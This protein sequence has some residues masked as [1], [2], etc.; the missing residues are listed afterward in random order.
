MNH[1]ER[2]LGALAGDAG[3]TQVI[4]EAIAI[5]VCMLLAWLVARA[6]FA[7]RAPSSKWQFGKGEFERVAF[8]FIAWG[9]LWIAK[10]ALDAVDAWADQTF[11]LGRHHEPP[12]AVAAQ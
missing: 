11:E 3:R 4:Y 8:P 7:K 1:L 5:A 10:A 2:V 6:V 9:F 12:L